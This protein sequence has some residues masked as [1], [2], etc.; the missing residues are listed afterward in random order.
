MTAAARLAAFAA[1][2]AI[3]FAGAALAG[4]AL[5]ADPQAQSH[6][7]AAGRSPG[8]ADDATAA[9]TAADRPRATAA[10]EGN[11]GAARPV[12][13]LGLSEQGLR[14]VVADTE[15][16]RDRVEPL[17]YR[18]VDEDGRTVRDFDVEHGK[19]M[20]L[21]L[22]RR[23]LTGFQHLHPTQRPDGWWV[24]RARLPRAG[25][26]KMFA[27]FMRDG[28][29]FTPAAD[30]RVDGNAD[31]RDLPPPGA[32]ADAGAGRLVGLDADE[33]GAGRPAELRFTVRRGGRAVPVEPYLGADG[34][35]VALREGDMAYLHVHPSERGDGDSIG[36][37]ATFPSPGRYR[38]FLQFKDRGRVRTAAFT[39][40]V[41]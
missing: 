16:D 30:L 40:Q 11:H 36:F 38:L 23:D 22:A 29:A 13:G 4:D 39:H 17:R 20:H 10:A 15:L 9:G 27:D 2:L 7:G 37:R 21:I 6:A 12:R 1:L 18:I 34:H 25:S 24:T 41:S 8:H 14:L 3:V 35:L 5:D 31:L 19:R 32:V 33:M 26:Y 28:D